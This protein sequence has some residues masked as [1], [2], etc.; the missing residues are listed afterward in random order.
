MNLVS[1]TNNG[2]HYRYG[3]E[4]AMRPLMP[5]KQ[6]MVLVVR[7]Q[8]CKGTLGGEVLTEDKFSRSECADVGRMVLEAAANRR[9]LSVESCSERF[10][11]AVPT[12]RC[13]REAPA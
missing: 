11:I 12:C 4:S 7:C 8:H 2:H 13:P 1:T 5:D 9:N 6:Y 3:S 10:A